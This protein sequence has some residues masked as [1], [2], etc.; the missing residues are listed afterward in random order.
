MAAGEDRHSS[1]SK[2]KQM[3][4]EIPY[5]KHCG[6]DDV[7]IIQQFNG[8]HWIDIGIRKINQTD[9]L[10]N[11]E[12][13]AGAS[14]S[15]NT[16]ARLAPSASHQWTQCTGSIALIEANRHRIP[17]DDRSVYSDEGTEAHDHA[18]NILLGKVTLEEIPEKF[19]EHVGAYIEHCR[20]AAGDGLVEIEVKVPLFY[21][22]DAT[23]TCDFISVSD[24]RV[25]V[26]DL[27]YGAGVLVRSHENEQL[28]IYALSYLREMMDAGLWNFEPDTVI[29][30]AVF[31]PRHREGAEQKPWVLTLAELENFCKDIDYAAIQASEGL[32][33]VQNALPCGSRD[34]AVAEILEAAP[35]LRFAPSDGDS[36][37]CRWCKAKGFC[38]ARLKA[39]LADVE[40]PQLEFEELIAGMPEATKEEKK[41]EPLDRAESMLARAATE[42]GQLDFTGGVLTDDYLV[43]LFKATEGIKTFL[44]DVAEHLEARVVAGA[45]IPG[46]KL[47]LGREGNRAWSDEDAADKLLAQSGKLKMEQRYKMALISPTQAESL[48]KEKIESSTRFR[49]CFEA[50]V[51][52]NPA[53]PVL[54]LESD[55]REAV[56]AAV[57]DMP[58]SEDEV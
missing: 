22:P 37:A 50:L 56:A 40:L 9:K 1:P 43:R 39:A 52:R 44:D 13:T 12:N 53:R 54:A 57:Q 26:R 4:R 21:Q 27:K 41:M 20:A 30:I 48:L 5:H 19:R 51:Q 6:C 7:V 32:R 14:G 16:H 10:M 28:A 29:D 2:R 45:H 31:Q 49:N 25:V 3:T 47:V 35:G 8:H 55:K 33:R 42:S 36:G 58:V 18:A 34:I 11:T 38:E 23:G 46:L 15:H 24:E 17:K